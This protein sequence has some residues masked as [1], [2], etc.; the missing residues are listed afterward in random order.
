ML[1]AH[2]KCLIGRL[3]AHRCHK[4]PWIPCLHTNNRPWNAATS[5]DLPNQLMVYCIHTSCIGASL[6]SGRGPRISPGNQMGSFGGK[7][8]G[9]QAAISG[10][11]DVLSRNTHHSGY[12]WLD[13]Q[14]L[15]LLQIHCQ[16]GLRKLKEA[17]RNIKG[18]RLKRVYCLSYYRVS[19]SKT[20]CLEGY[21]SLNI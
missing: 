1:S 8:Q 19:K 16:D 10:M 6:I 17:K 3:L 13:N 4:Q 14:G 9:K 21:R 11:V 20:R 2:Y 18:N 5:T 12:I 15:L 7:T